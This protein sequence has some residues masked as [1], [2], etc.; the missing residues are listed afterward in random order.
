[1]NFP[2]DNELLKNL[3]YIS[4]T[5]IFFLLETFLNDGFIGKVHVCIVSVCQKK[6][7]I[8]EYYITNIFLKKIASFCFAS[9]FF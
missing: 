1:M 6:V 7:T 4:H 9:D 8:V 3:H 5:S 2:V